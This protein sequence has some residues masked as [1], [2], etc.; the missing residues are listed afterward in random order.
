MI[1]DG[2]GIFTKVPH[3]PK[4]VGEYIVEVSIQFVMVCGSDYEAL[5]L[6]QKPDFA[7]NIEDIFSITILLLSGGASLGGI[8]VL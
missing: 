3:V 6:E 5:L 7:H 1:L 8:H 2:Y 4:L